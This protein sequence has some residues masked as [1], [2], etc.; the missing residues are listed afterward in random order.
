MYF[1]EEYSQGAYKNADF[2]ENS[3]ELGVYTSKEVL[4]EKRMKILA[5]EY[6]ENYERYISLKENFNLPN[7]ADFGFTLS[8]EGHEEVVGQKE[9]PQRAEVFSESRRVSIL[10]EDGSSVF[11]E[12]NIKIW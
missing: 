5:E 11:G 9:I 3:Y 8:I 7:N 1:N 12:L 6:A 2:L 4:S 10:L